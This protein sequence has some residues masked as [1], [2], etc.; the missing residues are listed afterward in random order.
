MSLASSQN[1]PL[2]YSRV[3][4][5]QTVKVCVMMMCYNIIDQSGSCNYWVLLIIIRIIS[6][7]FD[8]WQIFILR[9]V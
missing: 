9:I 5:V 1:L 6:L 2:N 7:D 8:F 3:D 4:R